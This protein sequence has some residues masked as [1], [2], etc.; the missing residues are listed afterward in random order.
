MATLEL[1]IKTCLGKTLEEIGEVCLCKRIL[2]K[3]N[4]GCR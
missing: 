2:E 3:A 1:Q 4:F